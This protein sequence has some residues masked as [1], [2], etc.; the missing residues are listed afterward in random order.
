MGYQETFNS[1]RSVTWEEVDAASLDVTGFVVSGAGDDDVA[2]AP[3][4]VARTATALMTGNVDVWTVTITGTRAGVVIDDDLTVTG[5]GG[6]V[7]SVVAFDTITNVAWA[8][9]VTSGD[10]DI[11]W[12]N[13]FG[14][15]AR[16]AHA[17]C[18]LLRFL[19]GVID[20]GGAVRA[21][22]GNEPNGTIEPGSFTGYGTLQ[23]LFYTSA[24]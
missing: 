23:A 6:A 12:A 22:S 18:V 5:G 17:S 9:Q 16:I 3:P 2:L 19:D 4:G 10:L 11:A 15:P 14:L 1:L 13:G 21:A 20:S 24:Y 8:D 7:Q